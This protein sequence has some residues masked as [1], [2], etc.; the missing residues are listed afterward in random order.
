MIKS[1]E[2]HCPGCGGELKYYDKVPRI[3]IRKRRVIEYVF[4]RRLQCES[5]GVVHRELPENVVHFK[6]YEAEII[7]GV[8]EGLITVETLGFE[9][10][11]CGITMLRWRAS[12][13]LQAVL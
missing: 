13:N 6:H 2:T 4:V 12:Q 7:R 1:G 5:C 3:L 9:D 11:P 10:Y 8:L